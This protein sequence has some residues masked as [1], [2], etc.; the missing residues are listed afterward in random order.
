MRA[1]G[2]LFVTAVARNFE[3][4]STSNGNFRLD[5][6]DGG[7]YNLYV[8]AQGFEPTFLVSRLELSDVTGDM[9]VPIML[10]RRSEIQVQSGP[11]VLSS[12]RICNSNFPRSGGVG[13][14]DIPTLLMSQGIIAG[15]DEISSLEETVLSGPN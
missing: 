3:T 13:R 15:T 12:S 9:S 7:G 11:A 8:T 6:L 14:A 2:P 4:S 1:T 10:R 5:L